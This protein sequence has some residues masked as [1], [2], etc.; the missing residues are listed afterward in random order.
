[1]A[2]HNRGL[3]L[4]SCEK[5][6]S[7]TSTRDPE[8]SP[9]E[10]ETD[11]AQKKRYAQAL[12]TAAESLFPP[13]KLKVRYSSVYECEFMHRKKVL[14][15]LG[16]EYKTPR[17]L[18]LE[19]HP[20]DCVLGTGARKSFTQEKLVALIMGLKD[21]EDFGG[22]LLVRGGE[23]TRADDGLLPGSMG[24]C[25]QR[26]SSA[27]EELGPFTKFQASEKFNGSAAQARKFLADQADREQTLTKTSFHGG[28]ELLGLKYFRFLIRER[29]LENFAIDHFLFY[30]EK[31]FLSPF[32]GGFLQKRHE[33]RSKENSVLE[34][35]TLKLVNNTVY[36]FCALESCNFTKT[37]IM[38]EGSLKNKKSTLL[39]SPD[40]LQLTLLGVEE[41][42]KGKR[43]LPQLLYAV[44]LRSSEAK[45]FNMSQVSACILGHSR[46]VFLEKVLS[47]LRLLDPAKMEICYL[48][49]SAPRHLESYRI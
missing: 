16:R 23:E 45:I 41:K 3:H 20:R 4:P 6:G 29:G 33:L 15:R 38:T 31:S 13:S 35:N 32:F 10:E 21:E 26:C 1:M 19:K 28:G 27:S 42:A 14:C 34:R 36:G 8:I 18:L 9:W 43:R 22:F 25:H 30:R 40:L 49:E 12:T 48:G 2:Y 24:F 44:S 39:Q 46:N 7:G 11:D 17:K 47:L 37:R 5:F